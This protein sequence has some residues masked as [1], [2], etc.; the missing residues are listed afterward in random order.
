MLERSV[1]TGWKFGGGS[2]A[3]GSVC[4]SRSWS[5]S[6][7]IGSS[8]EG[9]GRGDGRRVG[10]VMVWRVGGAERGRNDMTRA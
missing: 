7:F 1:K 10:G 3:G 8:V 5:W 9:L 6:S 4:R 2:T